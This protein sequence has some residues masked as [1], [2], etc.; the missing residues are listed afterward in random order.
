[1]LRYLNA[2]NRFNNRNLWLHNKPRTGSQHYQHQPSNSL[3]AW[4]FEFSRS[5]GYYLVSFGIGQLY[6]SYFLS[7]ES[8]TC[9]AKKE[10][11]FIVYSEV[12]LTNLSR[13]TDKIRTFRRSFL[14]REIEIM[15][16][17]SPSPES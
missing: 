8:L 16:V 2:H 10:E 12:F 17:D 15:L 11:A 5:R 14:S 3:W 6:T 4:S 9:S 13:T 1:M 7:N